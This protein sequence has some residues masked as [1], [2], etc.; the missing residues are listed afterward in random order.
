ML[1]R[2][3]G[4]QWHPDFAALQ[5]AHRT[6]DCSLGGLAAIPPASLPIQHPLLCRACLA[7]C[8]ASTLQQR[9]A[10]QTGSPRLLSL[11]ARCS[12]LRQLVISNGLICSDSLEAFRWLP[13][14]TALHLHDCELEGL[15]DG[16]Y[17]SGLRR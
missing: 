16:P 7:C 8:P 13:G 2:Q 14:L 11:P 1:F 4:R 9:V 10:F 3:R 15:P 5:V 6:F 17:L 12:S